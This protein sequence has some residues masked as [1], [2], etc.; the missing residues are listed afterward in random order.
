[1]SSVRTSSTSNTSG[2][3]K[4][5]GSRKQAKSPSNNYGFPQKKRSAAKSTSNNYG[6]NANVSVY[7]TPEG[8]SK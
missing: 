4:R 5:R 2:K 8:K 1:M 3:G 6:W 7:N